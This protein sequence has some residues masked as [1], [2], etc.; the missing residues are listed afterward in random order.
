MAARNPIPIGAKFGKL[1]IIC[2]APKRVGNANR[3][4]SALCE[5]GNAG[6]FVMSEVLNGVTKSC[7]CLIGRNSFVH[8]HTIRKKMSPEYYSWASMRTR[9]QN[10]NCEAY[11][12]YGGRGISVHATWNDFPTFLRDMG[13]R[14]NGASLERIDNDGNYEPGNCRWASRADQSNNR[15]SNSFYEHDGKRMTLSQWAAFSNIAYN[16]LHARVVRFKWDFS[17]ALTRPP[18]RSKYTV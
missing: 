2:E 5:C 16:T 18:G 14:P 1:T 13:S 17:K 6:T 12:S 7:G 4:V 10:K 8:G 9:C 3:R 15:R 11:P